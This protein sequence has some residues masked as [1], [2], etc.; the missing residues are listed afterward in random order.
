M[1]KKEITYND[2]NGTERT[3]SFYFNLTKAELT[4]MELGTEGGMSGMIE[5]IVAEQDIQRIM[6]LFKSIIQKAYGE[7]S[8]DGRR[9]VKNQEILDNFTQTE[10]YSKLFMELAT[11]ADAAAEFINGLMPDDTKV[12]D[13]ERY[14]EIIKAEKEKYPRETPR[15]ILPEDN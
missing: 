1:L 11:N 3:E 14:K 10:A 9:F 8:L 6:E 2:F 12:Q 15:E 7:K 5:K 13:T 4:E